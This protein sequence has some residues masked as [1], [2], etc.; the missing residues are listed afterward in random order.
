MFDPLDGSS[1]LDVA[2]GVGTIFSI[3]RQERRAEKG[4]DWL[5]QPGDEQVAAGYILYGSST[6][7]MLTLGDG[8]D[9]FVLDPAIGAWTAQ[10]AGQLEARAPALV[11]GIERDLASL[12]PIAE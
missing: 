12:H 5:L 7:F 11:A 10:A 8:V 3:L 2:G 9:M 4:E 1:N 6:I